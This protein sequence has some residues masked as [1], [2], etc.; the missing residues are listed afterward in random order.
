MDITVEK[1]AAGSPTIKV[2]LDMGYWEARRMARLAHSSWSNKDGFAWRIADAME[3][4]GIELASMDYL[5]Q[6]VEE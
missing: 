3:I 5:T 1:Y 6:E 2:T 4:E